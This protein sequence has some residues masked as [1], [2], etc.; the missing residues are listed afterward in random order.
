M[1]IDIYELQE[2]ITPQEYG[3][4]CS[5][6]DS[7]A[8][9]ALESGRAYV[10]MVAQKFSLDY[11]EDDPVLRMAVKKWALAQMYI[12]AA[13]WETAELYKKECTEILAPLA[14]VSGQTGR[15]FSAGAPGSNSWKGFS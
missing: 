2:C 14:P 9:E 10:G 12:F 4:I 1:L 7:I 5:G 11:D 13:E 3:A 8:E 15:V 6:D